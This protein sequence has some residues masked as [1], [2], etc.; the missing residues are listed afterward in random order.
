[1]GRLHQAELMS[2]HLASYWFKHWWGICQTWVNFP[3][4]VT[5]GSSQEQ[6]SYSKGTGWLLSNNRNY[7]CF[8]SVQ[9]SN[10]EKVMQLCNYLVRWTSVHENLNYYNTPGRGKRGHVKIELFSSLWSNTVCQ[11]MRLI[12]FRRKNSPSVGMLQGRDQKRIFLC[13][14]NLKNIIIYRLYYSISSI[15]SWMF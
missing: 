5:D 14:T 2:A 13:P 6:W 4:S 15:S 12:I 1:M 8:W 3:F 7:Y 9:G 10:R 11:Y